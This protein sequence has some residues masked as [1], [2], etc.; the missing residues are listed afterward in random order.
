M[1]D[2]RAGYVSLEIRVIPAFFALLR[3]YDFGTVRFLIV[4][5]PLTFAGL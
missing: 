5:A 4:V 2:W 3:M 1:S